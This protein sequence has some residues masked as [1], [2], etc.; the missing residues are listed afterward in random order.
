MKLENLVRF[1]NKAISPLKRKVLLMIGRGV[2]LA[3]TDSEKIQLVQLSLLEG[4]TKDKVE[5]FAHFGFTSNPPIGSD[6]IMLSVGG[7]RE[8]GIIIGTEHRDF[9]L[10]D[11]A[12]GDSAIYNKNNK[13]IWLKGD[14]IEIALSKLKIEN[15]SNEL[16]AVLS[17]WMEK[18]ISG[19]VVTA[20]GPQPWTP[21]TLAQLD[22]VKVKMDSFKV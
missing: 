13:Y 9:R 7:N 8:H 10:K 5:S 1:F 4:E 3:V 11:L 19:K 15:D 12:S 18:V 17:E 2:M 20:I 21:D 14:D 16:M 6:C 22:A